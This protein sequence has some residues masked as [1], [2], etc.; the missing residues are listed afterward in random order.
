MK[1]R[2]LALLGVLVAWAVV[3]YGNRAMLMMNPV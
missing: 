3:A 1:I 2:T